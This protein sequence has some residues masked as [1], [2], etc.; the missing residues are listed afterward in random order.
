M[1]ITW[2]LY[3]ISSERRFFIMSVSSPNRGDDGIGI[4][5]LRRQRHIGCCGFR[6]SLCADAL[7]RPAS[8]LRSVCFRQRPMDGAEELFYLY[9]RGAG[10]S[11][12]KKLLPTGKN[13]F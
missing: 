6:E 2:P 13:Y 3:G 1:K 9:L 8:V 5:R 10:F 12:Q 7:C 11:Y 4:Y